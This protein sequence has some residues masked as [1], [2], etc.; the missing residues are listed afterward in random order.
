M[1]L[2]FGFLIS[3]LLLITNAFAKDCT[4]WV[5]KDGNVPGTEAK[6]V[7]TR[8]SAALSS[9]ASKTC[10]YF[11]IVL[12]E[13]DFRER[14]V[15]DRSNV[16]IVGG[17]QGK[18]RIVNNLYADIAGKYYP[19]G[20][21]TPGSATMVIRGQNVSLKALT[22]END[23]DYL[24]SD[25][26]PKGHKEKVKAAQAV[27]LLLDKGS[28]MVWLENVSLL[29][30]QDTL[31]AHGGRAY[32]NKSEIAGNVDFIF[33]GGQ[34]LIEDSKIISR[35]RARTHKPGDIQ[36]HVTAPSTSIKKAYGIVFKNCELLAEEG[37]ADKSH[38]LGRPWHPTTTFED[39]RYADPEAIGYALFYE[40]KMGPHISENG[41]GSMRGTG[42]DGTKSLTFTPD[43]SRFYE[44]KSSG[45][46]A[47]SSY[48]ARNKRKLD[49]AEATM[50]AIEKEHFQ[51]WQLKS[52]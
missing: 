50:K 9:D 42:R 17:G 32:I 35:K 47:H 43:D 12:S 8:L 41:W 44:W 23:F 22:V 39:G 29:G 15:V 26:L 52:K 4:V 37:V 2:K 18:T 20:W 46:G 27:A 51:G 49:D 38:T 34:V 19:E 36:G 33:G 1:A 24:K 7:F 13:G 30:Y 28:D 3:L 6:V 40:T 5:T 11:K 31:F 45:E 10:E 14:V 21:G 48:P 16:E 25:A